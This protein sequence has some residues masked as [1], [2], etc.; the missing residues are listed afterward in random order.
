M[1]NKTAIIMS[2]G[3]MTCS[4]G[5][6][7]ILALAEKYN[8]E[9]PDIVIAGSGNAGTL[10]YFVT[11]QYDFM[12][13]IWS[14]L[15]ATKKF[16]D[17]GRISKIVDIDYLVDEVIKKQA[18]IDEEKIYSSKILYLI[19]ATNVETGQ[20]TFFSNHERDDIFEAMRASKAMPVVYNKK[21]TIGKK[22][23]CDSYLSTSTE[24]NT[25]KA[26]QL[27]ANRIIIIDNTLPSFISNFVFLLWL[28][29]K[30]KKFKKNYL[31]SLKRIKKIKFPKKV[32]LI[33]LKPVKKLK[34]S[35]LNNK[36]EALEQAIKQGFDETCE[37]LALKK[38][39]KGI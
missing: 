37:N 17:L 21:I 11:R 4:Y 24:L 29:F 28:N 15:L 12:I 30:S 33:K 38:F 7:S 39:L 26:I 6:G 31:K 32:Q 13:N 10:A 14:N 35:L 16:I 34:I 25:L 18:P 2:G 3:G 8:L 23:Y 27:G 36:H 20:V 5:A 1:K 19:P 9:K 22:K